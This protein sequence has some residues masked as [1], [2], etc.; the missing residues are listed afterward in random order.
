MRVHL[1]AAVSAMA[2]GL[3]FSITAWQWG[4]LWIAIVLVL[5]AEIVNTALEHLVDLASPGYAELA[6]TAKDVAAGAVFLTALAALALGNII[7]APYLAP[8]L[9][10]ARRGLA[11]LPTPWVL[12][13]GAAAL[14]L[15]VSGWQSLTRRQRW[16]VLIS[17]S[18]AT[19]VVQAF[20][21][22]PT[23]PVVTLG[24][25]ALFVLWVAGGYRLSLRYILGLLCWLVFAIW[26]LQRRV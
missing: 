5:F 24:F 17:A 21:H 8:L 15:L 12:G 6:R 7:F 18:V 2:C 3:W 25:L 16:L 22:W 11:Q 1:A 10:Q 14:L 9:C 23:L 13:A 4:L 20:I 26:F 19:L